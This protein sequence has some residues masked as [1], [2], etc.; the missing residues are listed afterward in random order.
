MGW[1][2]SHGS[3]ANGEERRSYTT[4]TNLAQHLAHVL[5]AGEWSE[6]AVVFKRG[7]GDPFTLPPRQAARCADLLDKAA[8]HV[9]MPPDWAELASTLAV[10]ARRASSAGQV[11]KWS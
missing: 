6:M 8:A 4:I 2:V 9:L 7:S 1:N 3:N 10:A 5:P 11:W